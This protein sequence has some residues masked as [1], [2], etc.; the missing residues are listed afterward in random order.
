MRVAFHPAVHYCWEVLSHIGGMLCPVFLLF[1][2]AHSTVLL[3]VDVY[4]G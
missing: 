4:I 1:S 2:P 3:L